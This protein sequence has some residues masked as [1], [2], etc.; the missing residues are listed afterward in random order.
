MSVISVDVL[1]PAR[2]DQKAGEH[3]KIDLAATLMLALTALGLTAFWIGVF[4]FLIP[5]L[6]R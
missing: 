5:S 1:R 3:P 6:T 4:L 2:P